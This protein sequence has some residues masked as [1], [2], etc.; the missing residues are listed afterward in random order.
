MEAMILAAG[1]GTRLRPLTDA[2]PK[3]LVPVRG[4]PLLA[5]VMDRLVAA[6]ATRIVV[7]TCRHAGQVQAWLAAHAPAGAEIALSHEPDGPYETGGGLLAAA[8]LFRREGPILLHNVDVLSRIPLA[9]LLAEHRAARA[10]A[11]DRCLATLA[12]QDRASARR[13][14]FDDDGLMGWERRGD[15]ATAGEEKRVRAAAGPVRS[16]A[17]AGIQVVE[18]AILDL[19]ERRGAFPIRDLYLDLAGRGYRMA[20][21]DASVHA[22]QDV[23]TAERLRAAEAADW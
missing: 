8:R 11:G 7:N 23:G 5:H 6:G 20:P 18:P 10:R 19:T 21:F 14:L 1:D 12:V 4:R 15:G 3:A 13:L 2:L 9:D 17:F 16:L 22:W